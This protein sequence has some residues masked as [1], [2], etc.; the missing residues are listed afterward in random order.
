MPEI[1]VIIP[2]Y[3]V[4]QYFEEC[5][6][7]VLGQT[8]RDLEIILVDDG[9]TD[10]SGEMCDAYAEKDS[11][12]HVLHQKNQGLSMA[13][14]NGMD[15]ATGRYFAFIDSDDYA[16]PDMMEALHR[17]ITENDADVAVCGIYRVK[18]K[19][20]TLNAEPWDTIMNGKEFLKEILIGSRVSVTKC[21][22]LFRREC[23][24]AVRF[25]A[26]KIT[27]DGYVAADLYPPL[28]RIAINLSP[29][30]YYRLREDSISTACFKLRDFDTI[31]AYDRCL[32]IVREKYP[33]C[34]KAAEMRTI[35]SRF[36]VYDKMLNTPDMEKRSKTILRRELL[37]RDKQIKANPYIFRTRK[38]GFLVLRISP[39]LYRWC[40]LRYQNKQAKGA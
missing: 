2:V 22:K 5:M 26:G 17:T 18:G 33:D 39:R 38:L 20:I 28:A 8:F 12:I 14:N 13:L 34:I 31:E 7:S 40:M 27:E 11:R 3:N 25:P 29:K 23:F 16:A 37:D 30:Y 1:S 6:A 19:H 4:K 24:D 32:S 21:D 35:W 9:S 36:F 10:G 15:M